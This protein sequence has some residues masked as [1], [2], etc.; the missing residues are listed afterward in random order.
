MPH[1][2][3]KFRCT[4]T[5]LTCALSITGSWLQLLLI[6]QTGEM[7]SH[8]LGEYYGAVPAGT[9]MALAAMG[10]LW[11]VCALGTLILCALECTIRSMLVRFW[12]H[13]VYAIGWMI[14]ANVMQFSLLLPFK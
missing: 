5:R 13:G 9:G 8:A 7:F 1:L 2:A 11:L 14:L 4:P 3:S 10:N 12:I 6:H